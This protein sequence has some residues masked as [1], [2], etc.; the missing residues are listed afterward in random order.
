MNRDDTLWKAI[1][2]D[3]FDDFLRFFIPDA[4]AIF[5]MERG[6]V[7][8][9]KELEQLFPPEQDSYRNRSV[10]KLVQVY[11]RAGQE[12]WILV[13]IEVQGKA[14]K[15]FAQRMF[16]YYSRIFD[17]YQRPISSFAILTD[18]SKSFRPIAYTQSLFGTTL[19]YTFT[20]YKILDQNRAALLANDNPF[21]VVALVVQTALRK[22]KIDEDE[23]LAL[24]LDLAKALLK[25]Q[26]SKNKVRQILNF[27]RYYVRFEKEENGVKFDRG[28]DQ[29]TNNKQ[30]MGLEEFLL[31]RAVTTGIKQGIEQ[32]I[33]LGIGRGKDMERH[34]MVVNMLRKTT[35]T[36]EQIAD[37]A[38]TT[39][40]FV[41][42]VRTQ[43]Q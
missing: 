18:G 12:Q 42:K 27:L 21:A 36:D 34:T 22:Q 13:H 11:T 17:K 40:D 4:D 43:L 41:K 14:D 28:L 31:H 7:F 15:T 25:K 37:V 2:E 35:L 23:L 16:T 3:I 30:T 1:L 26:F 10:D 33:D 20:S 8:L 39:L 19:T 5:D 32:G 9:D 29:L 38:N 24:K 6:F